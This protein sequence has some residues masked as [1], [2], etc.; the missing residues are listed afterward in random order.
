MYILLEY[1]HDY[2]S[3]DGDNMEKEVCSNVSTMA[4]VGIEPMAPGS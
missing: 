3:W 2:L 1:V 4:V